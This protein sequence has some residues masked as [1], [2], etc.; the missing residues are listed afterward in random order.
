MAK[1]SAHASAHIQEK[2]ESPK[3]SVNIQKRI[4]SLKSSKES[5]HYRVV[6]IGVSTGG[7]EA[8][9]KIIPLF[10]PNFPVPIVIVLHM[11]K[12][13]TGA[14][15]KDLDAKSAI[16]VSE[17]MD[18]DVL[19]PGHVYLA[20][21]GIHLII[22]SGTRGNLILRT[23]DGMLENGCK[24]AVDVL[25]KSAAPIVREKA[26]GVILTGMGIDG[27]EGIK[28]LREHDVPVIVQDEASSVVWGMPGNIVKNGIHCD[29]LP[30]TKIPDKIVEIVSGNG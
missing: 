19:S 4:S 24:P 7:P 25:F 6:L 15:A 9:V 14:M 1:I 18:N 20:P 11:P 21:G 12:L 23:K 17:A 16:T 29:V 3:N 8:L 2:S 5:S 27:T 26:I 13:F 30:L 28:T 10:P 22:E